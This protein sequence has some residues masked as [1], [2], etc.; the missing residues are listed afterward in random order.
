MTEFP[1][2][3]TTRYLYFRMHPRRMQAWR[4]AD[5]L[6]GRELTRCDRSFEA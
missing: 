6:E 2:T 5:E 1:V 3:L 4:E